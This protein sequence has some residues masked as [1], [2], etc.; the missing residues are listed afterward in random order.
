[1]RTFKEKTIQV[2]DDVNCD[3]C[4]K[5]TTNY[6][7]VGPDY[8]TLESCWG[9]GSDNDGSKYHIDL[10][11]SCFF[12]VLNFIREKRRKVLGPFNY[13]YDQDPLDG[14]EYL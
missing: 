2:V 6:A 9:Y 7:D 11:E 3:A 12:E 14:I 4:G 1:M 10:C 13:P 8:A 5:S